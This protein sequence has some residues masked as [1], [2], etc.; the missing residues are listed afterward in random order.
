LGWGAN[1]VLMNVHRG[2]LT[3]ESGASH[4]GAAEV[5]A[6]LAANP[7]VQYIDCVFVDLCGNVRGKRVT[8]NE[9]GDVFRAGLA[10]PKSIYFL[11]ARGEPVEA[12]GPR[13]A[14]QGTAWPVPGSLTPVSWAQRPH[15]QVLMTLCDAT[16]AAFFGEPRNV[17]RRVIAR[18]AEFDAMPAVGVSFDVCIVDRERSKD[19]VPRIMHADGDTISMLRREVEAAAAVESLPEVSLRV[20]GGQLSLALAC[21]TDALTAADHA[22]LLRQSAR[23]VARK[24]KLDAIFMAKPFAGRRGNSLGATV[25]VRR[26]SGESVF[27]T[28]P[29]GELVRFGVGG[30]QALAAESLAIFAPSVN[31]FRRFSD[32]DAAPRN[33]HWGFDHS[34]ANLSV[35][36]NSMPTPLI[37]HRVASADANPYLV[38]AAILAGVHF[39]IAQNVDP[40]QPTDGDVSGFVDPT[41]PS[42]IDAALLALENGGV[43]REYLGP[44]Y[45]DLYCATKRAELER[46]RAVIPAHEYDWYA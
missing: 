28:T 4:L 26:A 31:A 34:T 12:L 14:S 42:S 37:A 24:L 36:T 39:G 19:G 18:F 6:F 43:V 11:D 10:I 25:D 20:D 17:L 40:G 7:N 33:R 15:G 27:A 23:A 35:V 21:E 16:G 13:V 29:G 9:L 1:D 44:D 38:V 2:A 30:L 3:S 22:V 41:F 46:F 45:V 5:D 32:N 8:L